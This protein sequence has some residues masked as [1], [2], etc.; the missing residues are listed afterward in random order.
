MSP[1]ARTALHWRLVK[2]GM[3]RARTGQTLS[4]GALFLPVVSPWARTGDRAALIELY[5]STYGENWEVDAAWFGDDAYLNQTGSLSGTG[6]NNFWSVIDPA[7]DYANEADPCQEKL[8]ADGKIPDWFG[9]HCEDPCYESIDG[10]DCRFGRITS[11]RL[12]ANGLKGTIPPSL[13]DNLVNLSIVDFSHNDISGTIPTEVG[14]LRNIKCAPPQLPR[15]RPDTPNQTPCAGP[16]VYPLCDAQYVS[17]RQ[18]QA[19]WHHSDRNLH[20]GIARQPVMSE[21]VCRAPCEW[22]W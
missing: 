14:K 6:G 8:T 10:P 11:I 19:V 12:P 4:A 5:E 2:P 17:A 13:F 20:H 1:L 18:Q 9:I 15:I 16:I 22:R 21:R 3:G 7:T